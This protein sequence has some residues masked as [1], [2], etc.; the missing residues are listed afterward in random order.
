MKTHE[1]IAR[2]ARATCPARSRKAWHCLAP[3]GRGLVCAI[4]L[5]PTLTCVVLE[6]LPLLLRVRGS[7]V[8][9]GRGF[10]G[11]TRR[12]AATAF[13]AT[14]RSLGATL[15]A[16]RG[17]AATAF[18]VLGWQLLQRPC[19]GDREVVVCWGEG[20]RLRLWCEVVGS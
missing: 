2:K 19:L 1:G 14:L 3:H 20:L 10:G 13:A 11:G 4:L 12:T 8:V 9:G 18:A 17:T 7:V 16:T 6:S 15:F 5:L